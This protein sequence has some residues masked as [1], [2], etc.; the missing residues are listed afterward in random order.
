[1]QLRELAVPGALEATPKQ[2]GDGRGTFLEWFKADVF[3]AAVGHAFELRQANCSVSQRGVLRGIHY[4]DVPPGQAKWVTCVSG[5]VLDV[6]VDLRVGSPTF[7][8]WDS[9][10]LDT[11]DRRGVYLPEGVGHAFLSLE[12]GSTVVY[13]CT[14]P[15]TPSIER[16]IH[17]LD[18][19]I[20]ISWPGDVTPLLSPKDEA[21][22]SLAQAEAAGLLP[23][24][25]EVTAYVASLRAG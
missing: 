20:G 2:H 11:V 7:G 13:L 22:P 1:M 14:T 4:A 21:A 25:D 17:P 18:P 12:D 9:V 23:R 10:L 16:E 5:S 15:Y 19:R 3:V 24:H 8:A 6:V